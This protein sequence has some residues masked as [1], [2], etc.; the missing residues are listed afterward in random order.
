MTEVDMQ[1]F[2][3]NE[4]EPTLEQA[5]ELATSGT[6]D[7]GAESTET[8]EA[9]AETTETQPVTESTESL[10]DAGDKT[11]TDVKAE[12][13]DAATDEEETE[14]PVSTKDGQSTIPY[15][16][17]KGSRQQVVELKSQNADI[18][19]ENEALRQQIE[20]VRQAG[21][22]TSAQPEVSNEVTEDT[23]LAEFQRKY[24][25]SYE[26]FVSEY[27]DE[28]AKFVLTPL[29]ESLELRNE[30]NNEL[31]AI[32]QELQ[33]RSIREEADAI[34]TL[35]AAIDANPTLSDWQQNN[36]A[37]WKAAQAVDSVLK[38]DPDWSGKSYQERFGEVVKRLGHSESAPSVET[39]D[40]SVEEKAKE[41]LDKAGK[42]VLTSLSSVSGGTPAAETLRDQVEGMSNTELQSQ[43]E[44]PD[45]MR[46]LLDAL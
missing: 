38:A 3:E 37:M 26:D 11:S 1:Y 29:R 13:E 45:K 8:E 28:Q 44:D 46:E 17:L 40:K 16:V 9:T 22:D 12:T 5:N 23:L 39:E 41:A 35:Q 10:E 2:L 14:A 6:V 20:E 34:D 19:A 27:G 33:D 31:T 32:R 15:S 36:E 4:I 43:M 24:G 7:L 18:A 25:Q 30:F 42:P 21:P